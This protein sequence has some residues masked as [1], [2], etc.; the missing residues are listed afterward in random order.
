MVTPLQ[1]AQ[2]FSVIANNGKMVNPRLVMELTTTE[3]FTVNSYPPDRGRMVL[4]PSTVNRLKYMLTSVTQYGTGTEAA[5]KPWITAGKTGTAQTGVII[6]EAEKNV[7]WFAG[8]TPVERP[9][10]VV[11]VLI[12]E[13]K[14]K[15]AAYVYGEIMAGILNL[16]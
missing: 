16:N 2:M 5:V 8:F 13:G 12:E 4:L 14:G 15:T 3:G 7:Y 9:E 10:A 11:V 1:V 6:D